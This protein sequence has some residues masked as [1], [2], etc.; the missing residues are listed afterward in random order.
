MEKSSMSFLGVFD[1]YTFP[2]LLLDWI[3]LRDLGK[4]DTAICNREERPLFLD[5]IDGGSIVRNTKATFSEAEVRWINKRGLTIR[6]TKLCISCYEFYGHTGRKCSW[7]N[8]PAE[9]RSRI[10]EDRARV[11]NAPVASIPLWLS[12]G[13]HTYTEGQCRFCCKVHEDKRL[14]NKWIC[15]CDPIACE[16]CAHERCP[17]CGAD[18]FGLIDA[19]EIELLLTHNFSNKTRIRVA[20]SWA[21]R[22]D[23]IGTTVD[24]A[25]LYCAAETINQVIKSLEAKTGQVVELDNIHSIYIFAAD[26]WNCM[27]DFIGHCYREISSPR[28]FQKIMASRDHHMDYFKIF[29]TKIEIA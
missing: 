5:F 18:K 20:R 4:L 1:E 2:A 15:N 27:Y 11:E 23:Y 26:P 3:T 13:I 19:A 8:L 7:C 17:T 29:K 14:I 22:H 25:Q 21:L 28:T 16:S 6:D 10:L 24:F 9:E 12:H